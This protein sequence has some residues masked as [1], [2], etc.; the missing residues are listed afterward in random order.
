MQRDFVGYGPV[1]PNA[2]WPGGARLALNFVINI[3]E[4]SEPSPLDGDPAAATGLTEVPGGRVAPGARDLGAESMF[5]YGSRA[6]FWRLSRLFAERDLPWTA[7]ACAQAVARNPAIAQALAEGPADL[8][9]H[10]LRWEPHYALAPDVEA[11]RIAEARETLM[12]LTGKPVPGWY[13]RYAPSLATRGILAAQ[14]GILYDSDSY[15]DDLPYWVTVSGR[16]HLVLPYTLDT[17]DVQFKSPASW[18]T[19]ADFHAYLADSVA[20]LRAEG[21]RQPRMMSVGL[22]CRIAGRPGRAAGLARFLDTLAA[23]PDVWVCRRVEIARHWREVHP[24]EG[25]A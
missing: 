4:G 21:A 19:G 6:G 20:L 7:F 18:G 25:A 9:G 14:E 10:G 12:R 3:E 11:A 22:H 1:P 8:C 23:M 17:N 24:P 13:C 2:A 5:E 15:A 16:A